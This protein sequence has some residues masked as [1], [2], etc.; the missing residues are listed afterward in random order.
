M[1][2]SNA[3]PHSPLSSE[4]P[5]SLQAVSSL[6]S[7]G[8]QNFDLNARI[9]ELQRQ[10]RDLQISDSRHKSLFVQEQKRA[11]HLSLVNE[12]QKC[13][14]AT[15]DTE[16]FLSQVT[17]AIG[18]HFADCDVSFYLSGRT[19]SGLFGN[20]DSAIR[21][22]DG[23][24]EEM[25]VVAS[26]GEH[27]LGP[28]PL[29]RRSLGEIKAAAAHPDALS[30]LSVP[31]S[32]D[33]EG[34][35]WLIIQTR[36][37][38]ILEARDEAALIT[39]AAIIAAHLQNSRLFRSMIEVNDFNQS[40][41]NSMMHSLLVVDKTGNIQFV[42]Q[43]L[44]STFGAS[45]D[46]F[47]KQPLERVF[48]EG[49][50][51]HHDLH[52]VIEGV[53][54]TGEAAEVPEVHVWSPDGNKIF[55]VRVFRVYFRG[56]AEAALLLINLTLRWRKTYQLQLMHE[57][58]Q[59]FQE[60]VSLN[61]NQVL[62]TVLTCITAGSA[63]GF[64]RAFVFLFD[65]VRGT[66]LGRMA[67]GPSS[68]D[69]AGR[70]WGDISQRELSL[71][72]M[73]AQDNTPERIHTPLQEETRSLVGHP[74]NPC[75]KL[76]PAMLA[77]KRAKRVT[78]DEWFDCSLANN[79]EQR[80]EA[81]RFSA[82]LRAREM[83]V[84]PLVTKDELIGVIFADNLYSGSVIEDDDVQMLDT[85]A[86]QACLAI[87]NA[88]TFQS[89]QEAQR[90]LVAS[91]R[92]VAVGEMSARVS[93]EIRNPLATIGGFA[94]SILKKPDDTSSV[95]RK[96]GVIV[97]EVSRLEDLL[98]DLLDMARPRPLK[99]KPESLNEIADHSLLLAESDIRTF[100]AVVERDFASDLP[101]ADLDRS[102]LLQA[103]LNTIRNGVQ[104]MPD[105]GVIRIITRQPD[106]NSVE[107]Q[108]K[109]SGVGIPTKALK[110][111]FN[112][113]FSTK[114]SGS[115]LGLAVTKKIIADH[116]GTIAVQSQEGAGTTFF[117]KLPI[118]PIGDSKVT[119]ESLSKPSS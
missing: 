46:D 8:E 45:R 114:V 97:A 49:P 9:E 55:D 16:A 56:H 58:G 111:V 108:I 23:E 27:D 18:S 57:I 26:A 119:E 42:N 91:E 105:G 99:L 87:D 15:R 96:T 68:P 110:E 77:E 82:L 94:R 86:G 63:L 39:S 2:D 28:L 47:R 3:V 33:G 72:E 14:L 69:E 75:Y 37:E 36:E 74:N 34:S 44:L 78:H 51:R 85:L 93:H 104:A 101:L 76:L 79:D 81:V 70:I 13:A 7:P 88:Q 21:F 71:E 73:L 52:K 103:L 35:G 48:G 65:P 90:E 118:H 40:L 98:T 62:S 4:V 92:L 41:L 5:S 112:P 53:I 54:E 10:I 60:S 107:I 1:I 61:V 109:D 102:R 89:L 113:F 19:L 50:A 106:A 6:S 30:F 95:K 83:A 66:F 115:G 59:L 100:G 43:R 17:R 67:L 11:R 32:A 38:D 29:S 24:G 22:W 12:V 84:A 117:F 80:E 64:N 31:V 116:G 20:D 25:I